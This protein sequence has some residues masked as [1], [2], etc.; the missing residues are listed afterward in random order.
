MFGQWSN[1]G[2]PIRTSRTLEKYPFHDEINE[3][4][5]KKEGI[6]EGML[7]LYNHVLYNLL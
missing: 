7:E 3:R 1:Q 4:K 6:L 5:I 2:I